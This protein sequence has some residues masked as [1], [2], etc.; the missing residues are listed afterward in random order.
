M[1]LSAVLIGWV[2]GFVAMVGKFLLENPGLLDAVGIFM[3]VGLA[4]TVTS[5]VWFA[6]APAKDRKVTFVWSHA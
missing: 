5:A 3:V 2:S 4:V 6:Y 1:M